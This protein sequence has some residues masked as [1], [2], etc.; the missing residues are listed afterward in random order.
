MKILCVFGKHNYGD[1]R[2]GE[3]YEYSNFLP[4]LKA[5]GH[6]VHFFE[7]WNRD[8]HSSFSALNRALLDRVQD[9]RPDLLFC[10]L[11]GYEVWLE[12]L[13]MVRESGRAELG[14]RRFVEV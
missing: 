12:T 13:H 2:R 11:M 5:L 7:S 6:E 10:V 8:C 3:G 9:L 14:H 4:A 1:P